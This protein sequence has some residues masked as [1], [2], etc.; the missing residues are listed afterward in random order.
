MR[1]GLTGFAGS[2]KSTL[3]WALTG[4][5]P[6]PSVALRGQTGIAQVKDGRLD[7]LDDIYKP[8][9]KTPAICEFIDTPGLISGRDES[10]SQRIATLRS[11]DSMAIVINGFGSTQSLEDELRSFID[12]LAFADLLILTNRIERIE[13]AFRKGKVR[14]DKKNVSKELELLKAF[15][16]DLESSQVGLTL[17]PPDD[18][19]LALRGFL[20][21][22]L[23]PKILVLNVAEN[24]SNNSEHENFLSQFPETIVLS[25]T[26]AKD[27]SQLDVDQRLEFMEE[28]GIKQTAHEQLIEKAYK[29]S[30]LISFFTVGHDECR[31]W[32]IQR[33][34]NALEAASKIHTD[35]ARGF[36]RAEVVGYQDFES[37]GDMKKVKSAGLHRLE[38]KQ[39]IIEDGDIIDFRFN[40]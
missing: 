31:A 17:N 16:E 30:G 5:Q 10:N 29:C 1:V 7:F 15:V 24:D 37:L 14:T 25:A 38:G 36:I 35:V 18:V 4:V 26:L 32:T 28:L 19:E 9:K 34:D 20:L 2:G 27:L 11:A 33:G 23:K 3:F 39:Y 12:E 8:K 21:F 22:C 40:V 13:E 6:D